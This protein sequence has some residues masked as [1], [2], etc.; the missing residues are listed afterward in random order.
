MSL[1]NNRLSSLNIFVSTNLSD[2]CLHILFLRHNRFSYTNVE[3]NVQLS[4][5]L[6]SL[7]CQTSNKITEEIKRTRAKQGSFLERVDR[8]IT[9]LPRI[10]PRQL[11]IAPS[12]PTL[13]FGKS[14][15]GIRSRTSPRLLS[16]RIMGPVRAANI[17]RSSNHNS[18][19][20]L[21]Q[22]DDSHFRADCQTKSIK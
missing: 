10:D 3:T 12:F 17:A 6:R 15:S 11:L 8:R 9:L 4:T 19:T 7:L 5:Q 21:S 22:V 14:F 20:K 1:N 2:Q 13:Q 16:T 18:I